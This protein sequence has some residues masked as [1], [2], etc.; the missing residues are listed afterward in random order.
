MTYISDINPS[1]PSGQDLVLNGDNEIRALKTDIKNTIGGLDAPVYEDAGSDGTGG[2]TPLKA[3]TISSWEARIA[4]LEAQASSPSGTSVPV[5]GI[6]VWHGALG[7]I[8]TGWKQCNG[9]R[10]EYTLPAGGKAQ[11]VTPDLRGRTIFAPGATDGPTQGQG[12]APYWINIGFGPALS[13]NTGSSGAHTHTTTTPGHAL[14]ND[15]IASHSHGMFADETPSVSGSDPGKVGFLQYATN[16]LT[17]PNGGNAYRIQPSSGGGTSPATVGVVSASGKN[18]AHTHP[19]STSSSNGAH[20]HAYSV[21][22]SYLCL[23]YIMYVADGVP[24]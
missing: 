3:T 2:S 7:T 23:Y 9:A 17:N 20:T 21:T 14:T 24:V 19:N 15:Q 12:L 1:T 4:A 13:A 6:M 10:Y 8:P 18:L 11:I 22:P 5:G 16:G